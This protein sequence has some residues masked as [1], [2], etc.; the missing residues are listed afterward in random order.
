MYSKRGWLGRALVGEKSSLLDFHPRSLRSSIAQLAFLSHYDIVHAAPTSMLMPSSPLR[1]FSP[2]RTLSLSVSLCLHPTPLYLFVS[3]PP[4]PPSAPTPRFPPPN[5]H[6]TF[7][8]L[9]PLA[10]PGRTRQSTPKVAGSS[11]AALR[12]KT[13][14]TVE[15]LVLF[16]C[17]TSRLFCRW[18]PVPEK[19]RKKLSSITSSPW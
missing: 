16:F 5:L 8:T 7:L 12:S 15:R 4:P 13:P 10:T 19:I 3:L 6:G 18:K 1:F 11:P 9:P 14:P 17:Y 2:P